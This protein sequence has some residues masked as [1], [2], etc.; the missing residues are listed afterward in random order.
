MRP[1][2]QERWNDYNKRLH[3]KPEHNC[4]ESETAE[5]LK[6]IEIKGKFLELGAGWGTK[7]KEMVEARGADYIGTDMFSSVHKS[8]DAHELDLPDESIDM[9]FSSNVFEHLISQIICLWEC[10]RVL[11][12]DGIIVVGL[13]DGEG[14]IFSEGHV[15]LPNEKQMQNY[16]QKSGFEFVEV[17]KFGEMAYYIGRKI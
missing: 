17:K 8:M 4:N 13:P 6:S 12:K 11:R 5:F 10:S 3:V 7:N 9:I 1:I 14:H 15:I 2:N 16:F